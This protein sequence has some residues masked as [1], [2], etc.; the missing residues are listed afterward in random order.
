MAMGQQMLQR[1]NTLRYAVI[2]GVI[3]AFAVGYLLWIR[4][5]NEGPAGALRL[6]VPPFVDTAFTVVGLERGAFGPLGLRLQPVQT[7]WENQYEILS[8]GGLD[9]SMS[10][11]DEFVN[12]SRNLN[13]VGRPVVF[14][15]P[16]WQFRGLGFYSASG[17]RPFSAFS[18]PRAKAEFVAQL[19]GRRVVVP[20]GSVFEQALRSFLAGSGVRYEDLE[21]VNAPLDSALNSLSDSSVAMVAVGS[22]QRFEAERRGFS[23]AIAPEALGLDV[24]TGFVVPETIYRERR[25]DVLDFVCGWYATARL[26]T[27]DPRGAYDI[28]NRY[29]VSR[30]ANSLTF[31]E[32]SALRAYDVVPTSVAEADALFLAP[33]GRAYWRTIW[34][35]SALAMTQV[36]RADQAPANTTGF[37]VPEVLAAAR[38]RCS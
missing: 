12:K 33:G 31:Q 27:S 35:R 2:L 3:L 22:Q 25:E 14:I 36:G 4:S 28:T 10:T 19:S 37:V 34:D 17:L 16:A 21:I 20:E 8:G 15:L 38:T 9:I 7:N 29:L 24:L 11:L 30:G 26:V 5:S 18:G 13:A 1:R 32:Y 23:E 6:S